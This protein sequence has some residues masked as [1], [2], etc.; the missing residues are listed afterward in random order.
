MA[1]MN[2]LSDSAGSVSS[3]VQYLIASWRK[4]RKTRLRKWLL[5]SGENKNWCEL[6]F[7][8]REQINECEGERRLFE[9]KYTEYIWRD[10][11]GSHMWMLDWGHP[12][13]TRTQKISYWMT[14]RNVWEVTRDEVRHMNIQYLC[15]VQKVAACQGNRTK[16][17]VNND[18][19]Q[20]AKV[21][22]TWYLKC[23]S[24]PFIGYQRLA[25]W[26]IKFIQFQHSSYNVSLLM[27]LSGIDSHKN[28]KSLRK[29]FLKPSWNHFWSIS[30]RA[31][32]EA[33]LRI[34]CISLILSLHRQMF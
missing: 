6:E 21:G 12:K 13:E 32:F 4:E 27:S 24:L 10:L 20:N 26:F 3:H 15:M 16:Q 33:L 9:V 18:I 14:I 8:E 2:K 25:F 19:E 17:L 23:R 7:Y 28:L 31:L 29:S 1:R 30:R 22:L 5:K 11:R 34:V